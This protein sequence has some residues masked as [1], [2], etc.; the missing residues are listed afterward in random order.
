RNAPA[1]AAPVAGA[2]GAPDAGAPTDARVARLTADNAR[3]TEQVKRSTIELAQLNRQLRLQDKGAGPGST[4]PT[5]AA[6]PADDPRLGELTQQLASAQS[7]LANLRA[8]NNR[9]K[10]AAAATTATPAANP[11]ELVAARD[12]AQRAERAVADASRQR[13]ALA[14]DNA[15]LQKQVRDLAARPATDPD[16]LASLR[17]QIMGAASDLGKARQENDALRTQLAT[18]QRAP[19][20]SQAD[21]DRMGE[22]LAAATRTI[23]EITARNDSLQKDLEV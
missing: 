21:L 19:A 23:A 12:A 22:Q 7:D 11:A 2:N 13:D 18:A 16:Q 6:T 9:L 8:E 10:Q 1:T 5:V 4:A 15:Q 3:L 20:A 17:E 14:A